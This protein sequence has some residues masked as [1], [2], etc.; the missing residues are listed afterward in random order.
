MLRRVRASWSKMGSWLQKSWRGS[1]G[2]SKGTSDGPLKKL[3]EQY[4]RDIYARA[5]VDAAFS[6]AISDLAAEIRED[7]KQEGPRVAKLLTNKTSL[8]FY[9]LGHT[10]AVLASLLEAAVRPDASTPA[11]VDPDFAALRLGALFQLAFDGGL[12]QLLAQGGDAPR[13]AR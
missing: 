1:D 10:Q 2:T 12:L 11:A 8:T 7:L 13:S 9:L 6:A 4:G 3:C 5:A